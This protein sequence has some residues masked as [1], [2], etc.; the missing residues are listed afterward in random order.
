[1]VNYYYPQP[2][3]HQQQINSV[4]HFQPNTSMHSWYAA[5]GL[6]QP[7]QL[8]SFCEE[9]PLWHP[10]A[11]YQQMF[12]HEFADFNALQYPQHQQ[13]PL[14]P[15]HQIPSPSTSASSLPSPSGHSGHLSPNITGNVSPN[16]NGH[17]SPNMPGNVSP[18]MTGNVSPIMTG[19]VSPN[20]QGN[21]SPNMHISSNLHGHL[22]PNLNGQIAPNLQAQLS[23][24]MNQNYQ[25]RPQP[26]RSPYEWIKKPSY[27]SQPN[28]GKTRTK[29]KYRVVYTDHQRVK[30]EK[31][32][33]FTNKYITIRRKMELASDLGLSERQI[34]IWFQNRRAKERKQIKKREEEKGQLN[35]NNGAYQQNLLNPLP[36]M[37][38]HLDM[39]NNQPVLANIPPSSIMMQRY[40]DTNHPLKSENSENA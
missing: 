31:E 11:G 19:Q 30:L 28:P 18:N 17:T 1:M 7:A 21:V 32:F 36:Q 14:I 40:I 29:D 16:M 34:K 2:M 22:P 37:Q 4:G 12:Q 10:H 23:L 20:M 5:T 24:N 9:Q 38:Q 6:R 13:H 27:Q 15:E 26:A 35:M 8:T 3:Y 33:L 39:H 25:S